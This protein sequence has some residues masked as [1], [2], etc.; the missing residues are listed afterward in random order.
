MDRRSLV[1]LH[2]HQHL[3]MLVEKEVELIDGVAHDRRS[4]RPLTSGFFVCPRT[5]LLR[6]ARRPRRVDG[7]QASPDVVRVDES[8]AY[9]RIDG[10]WYEIRFV[11]VPVEVRFGQ[12]RVYDMLLRRTIGARDVEPTR[13]QRPVYAASKR[14]LGKRE[15]RR[16]RGL[17]AADGNSVL[18]PG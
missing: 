1:K 13:Q 8:H 18:S 7:R 11:P 14:Q 12:A 5:G 2:V 15:V 10:I 3:W 6:E 17:I 4:C 9:H 16:L